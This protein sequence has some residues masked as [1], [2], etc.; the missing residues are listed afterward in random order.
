MPFQSKAQM[1][2]C[3]AK[4]SRGQ[5]KGWNCAEWAKKT[6]DPKALPEHVKQANSEIAESFAK[7]AK[8]L[9]KINPAAMRAIDNDIAITKSVK[10]DA[11]KNRGMSPVEHRAA[12]TRRY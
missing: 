6:K 2:A 10:A 7:I 4:K 5:A 8:A 3:F 9:M 1:K 11:I 12:T